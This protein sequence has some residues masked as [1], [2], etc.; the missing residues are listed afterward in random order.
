MLVICAFVQEYGMGMSSS[1]AA[2]LL[3]SRPVVWRRIQGAILDAAG[4]QRTCAL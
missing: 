3:L 1:R 2:R 4:V